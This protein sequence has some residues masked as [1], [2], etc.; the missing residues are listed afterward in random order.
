[1]V[2]NGLGE[3]A[4]HCFQNLPTRTDKRKYEESLGNSP[5]LV[6]IINVAVC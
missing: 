1:M 2:I 5:S 4:V 3:V 6:S